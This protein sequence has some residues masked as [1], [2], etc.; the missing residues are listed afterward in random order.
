MTEEENPKPKRSKK[1]HATTVFSFSHS[2]L[3]TMESCP[4]KWFLKYIR[5]YFPKVPIAATEFGKLLHKIGEDYTGGG[6]LEARQLLDLYKPKYTIEPQYEEKI[7]PAIAL[8]IDFH[9]K[10]LSKAKVVR[11][12]KEM[13]IALSDY[14]DL[15]GNLDVLYKNEEDEWVVVDYKTSKKKSDCS[16]QLAI[17]YFLMC[18]VSNQKPKKLRCQIVYL[19]LENPNQQYIDEYVLTQEELDFCEGRLEAAMNRIVNLGIDEIENWRKKT[20][21][22]CNYCNFYITGYCNGKQKDD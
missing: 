3:D 16:K 10:Y 20:G 17:Y 13:R 1:T 8:I 12:E 5:G 2:G 21:P 4:R 9:G 18:A 22:L 14:I 19:S 7:N 6:I 15:V 11:K